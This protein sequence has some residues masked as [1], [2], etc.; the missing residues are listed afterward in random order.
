LYHSKKPVGIGLPKAL[1]GADRLNKPPHPQK[2]PLTGSQSEPGNPDLEARP[3]L[4]WASQKGFLLNF[5]P[6]LD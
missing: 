1:K 4:V 5:P 6:Q 3:P 2:S